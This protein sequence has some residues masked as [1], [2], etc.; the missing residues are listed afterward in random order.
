MGKT[1]EIF[2]HQPAQHRPHGSLPAW[3]WHNP[4]TP[5][6]GESRRLERH[7]QWLS[8]RCLHDAARLLQNECCAYVVGMTAERRAPEFQLRIR[9]WT[10]IAEHPV[11]SDHELINL[12]STG[13]ILVARKP[14]ARHSSRAPRSFCHSSFLPARP[15]N[16]SLSG[17]NPA[18]W[19]PIHAQNSLPARAGAA[20]AA[21]G[22]P[23]RTS[24]ISAT[25]PRPRTVLSWSLRHCLLVGS[26]VIAAT[27]MSPRCVF[28]PRCG[29]SAASAQA[30]RFVVHEVPRAIDGIEDAFEHRLRDRRA[31]GK[32]HLVAIL[33]PLHDELDRPFPRPVLLEP[34][35]NRRLGNLVDL[36][37]RVRRRHRR[38]FRKRFPAF[39]PR[40]NQ[41]I[42]QFHL[43][44]TEQFAGLFER[45]RRSC[46]TTK[47]TKDAK[48][49]PSDGEF[50]L[51]GVGTWKLIRNPDSEVG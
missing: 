8:I 1:S 33:H 29:S 49:K 46:L 39:H 15:T 50:H 48:L 25:T 45:G 18:R 9:R 43:Q 31:A 17:K 21:T 28:A 42:A 7:A 13:H 30:E 23:V 22:F 24:C 10:Q 37:N 36:V 4:S 38:D 41:R 16:L 51:S 47:A 20:L 40:R 3:D 11:V 44:R 34:R 32:R 19:K 35:E 26:S 14:A 6:T 5:A 27:T 12:S 2:P